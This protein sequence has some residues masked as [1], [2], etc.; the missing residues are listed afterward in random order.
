MEVPV[1]DAA[2]NDLLDSLQGPSGREQESLLMSEAAS[3]LSSALPPSA[4]EEEAS[5]LEIEDN[6]IRELALAL[7]P[8]P[9]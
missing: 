7:R 5:D 3:R 9:R 1:S 4:R 6:V 8:R 2:L